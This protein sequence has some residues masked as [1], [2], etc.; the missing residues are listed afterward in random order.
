MN[1]E[2]HYALNRISTYTDPYLYSVGQRIPIRTITEN[3]HVI[4]FEIFR[5]LLKAA[6]P[7]FRTTSYRC[8]VAFTKK[9]TE[10]DQAE[11]E[12]C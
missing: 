7:K 3:F 4:L 9:M 11:D 5:K 12:K 1:N 8:L 6:Q 2:Q 10:V